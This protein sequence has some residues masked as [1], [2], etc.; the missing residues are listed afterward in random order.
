MTFLGNTYMTF[1]GS[2][3]M[4]L[5]V[6]ELPKNVDIALFMLLFEFIWVTAISRKLDIYHKEITFCAILYIYAMNT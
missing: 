5:H 6:S 4:L 3:E 2:S 1:L